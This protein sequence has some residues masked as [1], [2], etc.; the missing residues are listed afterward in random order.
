MALEDFLW[1]NKSCQIKQSKLRKIVWAYSAVTEPAVTREGA[2]HAPCILESCSELLADQAH[3]RPPRNT[4]GLIW[5]KEGESVSPART[6][7]GFRRCRLTASHSSPQRTKPSC[8]G[9]ISDLQWWARDFQFSGKLGKAWS[10]GT[11]FPPI[12]RASP[13]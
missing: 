2:L 6:L 9:S 8:Q 4:G 7:P 1:I 3:L 12:S 11:R 10:H 5:A 13:L